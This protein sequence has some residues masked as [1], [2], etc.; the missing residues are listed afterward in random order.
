M[1][2]RLD[3]R[4][5]RLV[6]RREHRPGR[7]PEDAVELVRERQLTRRQVDRPDPDV[8]QRL[9]RVELLEGIGEPVL[10]VDRLGDVREQ[11]TR[12]SPFGMIC[13]A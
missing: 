6:D 13:R 10:V 1:V 5:E 12:P 3:Q 7:Q 11:T 4:L 8:G 9:G 2:R